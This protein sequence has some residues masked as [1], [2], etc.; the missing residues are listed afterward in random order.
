MKEYPS[1]H[2]LQLILR[3]LRPPIPSAILFGMKGRQP[4]DE[5]ER[6]CVRQLAASVA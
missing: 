6:G 2:F 4:G 1:V 3:Q 5:V